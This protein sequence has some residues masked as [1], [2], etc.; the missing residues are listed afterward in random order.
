MKGRET[1]GLARL[2]LSVCGS[3]RSQTTIIVLTGLTP[4]PDTPKERKTMSMVVD[5]HKKNGKRAKFDVYIGR[6]IRYHKEFTEDSKWRNRSPT[7]EAYEDS[8]R[9]NDRLWN[10]LDELEGKILG[11]WCVTTE[12]LE[13]I[14]CHGQI[15]MKL[16]LEKV[17]ER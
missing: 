15:L 11:C 10:A 17:A 4:V 7:L 9:I 13:P 12:K 16:I 3:S 2:G 5:I 14:E 6:K 1:R 8:I